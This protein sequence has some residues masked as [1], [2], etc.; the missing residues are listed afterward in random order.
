LKY[1]WKMQ[2]AQNVGGQVDVSWVQYKMFYILSYYVI[3]DCSFNLLMQ[4]SQQFM[5]AVQG[6]TYEEY[7]FQICPYY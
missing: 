2:F 6:Q 7:L 3:L 5:P 1:S 4:T